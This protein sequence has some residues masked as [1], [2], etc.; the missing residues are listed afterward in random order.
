MNTNKPI[1]IN[2]PFE[3]VKQQL[4][5]DFT[6]AMCGGEFTADREEFSVEDTIAE[7]QQR[8]GTELTKNCDVVCDACYQRMFGGDAARN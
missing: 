4:S 1:D 2:K 6:C 5:D 7:G 3:E 8:F